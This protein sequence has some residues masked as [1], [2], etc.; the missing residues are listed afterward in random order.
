MQN[1]RTAL[2]GYQ[3]DVDRESACRLL[4]FIPTI[5]I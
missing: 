5:A 4:M 2:S 1:C 3:T